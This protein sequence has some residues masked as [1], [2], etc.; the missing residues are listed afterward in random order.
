MLMQRA[1]Q[2]LDARIG[3]KPDASFRPRLVRALRDVAEAKSMDRE[4][5]VGA[6]P[7][8][9]SLFDALLD[10][11]TVQES[12][13]FRHPEH[14]EILART[15]LPT[16]RAPFRAWSAACANGQEAYSLAMV[17]NEI[18]G[19]G[20]VL[21]TDISPAAL[22]RA[23][24]GTFKER[25]MGGVSA[26]RRRR[27]FLRLPGDG[28][29]VRQHLREM[30]TVQRHNL[31]DPIPRQVATC[32]VVM[33]RNVLIYFEQRHAES[34]LERLADAMDPKA[35]LLV[36][37]AETLW[38]MTD[39]FEPAQIGV[40][41]VYRPLARGSSRRTTVSNTK[42]DVH[43]VAL[44]PVPATAVRAADPPA[45]PFDETG[46]EY[47][48]LGRQIL[49]GGSLQQAIVAFRQWA[50]LSPDDPVAHFE[51]GSAL[52]ASGERVPAVRAFRAALAALDRCSPEELIDASHGYNPSELRRFLIQKCLSTSDQPDAS[53][54]RS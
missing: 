5:L 48:R 3:L 20:C 43:P 39:R 47:G 41:Y 38:Q 25:E 54:A 19:S 8:D 16:F 22:E 29:H 33:C 9:A 46:R 30:V 26:D 15:V 11:V 7:T 42:L 17:M 18:G 24:I 44:G 27:H 50:Y 36:G 40:S 1:A 49:A 35:C 23:A 28:W 53:P 21:A 12:G 51:L 45:Q 32:Q 4:E 10:Q 52:D 2:L 13:F 31:L 37:A 14:F 6:L 34:F